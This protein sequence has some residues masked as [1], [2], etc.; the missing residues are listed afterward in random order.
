MDV[1]FTL[2]SL[3]R[4]GVG[5]GGSFLGRWPRSWAPRPFLQAEGALGGRVG[6]PEGYDQETKSCSVRLGTTLNIL[7]AFGG[8]GWGGH[9]RTQKSR[10]PGH[11]RCCRDIQK[12][13]ARVSGEFVVRE[14]DTNDLNYHKNPRFGFHGAAFGEQV[15]VGEALGKSR[16]ESRA[17]AGAGS[18]WSLGHRRVLPSFPLPCGP[19]GS[20]RDLVGS[21]CTE[22]GAAVPGDSDAP[23]RR[24]AVCADPGGGGTRGLLSAWPTPKWATCP[25]GSQDVTWRPTPFLLYFLLVG[26]RERARH[27]ATASPASSSTPR[28]APARPPVH[29]GCSVALQ[30]GARAPRQEGP[31][32]GTRTVPDRSPKLHDFG[33][34]HGSLQSLIPLP[35]G[36]SLSLTPEGGREARPTIAPSQSPEAAVPRTA[37]LA[38]LGPHHLLSLCRTT[39]GPC[40]SRPLRP[41]RLTQL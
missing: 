31:A 36:W 40:G 6:G 29:S 7:F 18:D 16:A 11:G 12:A 4:Y 25:A 8:C 39:G 17:R 13:V 30:I 3:C 24:S 41:S 5:P 10:S 38:I 35:W 23:T 27:L 2:L 1:L 32:H 37:L 20:V 33:P 9:V 21:L 22:P 28:P 14:S 19:L 34:L 26:L 15:P